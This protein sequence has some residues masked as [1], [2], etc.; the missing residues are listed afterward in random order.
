MTGNELRSY[1]ASIMN[2]WNGA[3][4]GSAKHKEILSIYNA[5]KPLARGYS[6]K[7]SDAYCATTVSAA[8]IK[9][10]IS[11]YTGTECGV[12][13]LVEIAQAK[14]IWVENDA[15]TPKVG[16]AVVYDWEDGKD[17]ATTDNRGDEDHVGI[18]TAV[19]GK[20]F[21]V[22]EGNI[23]QGK[24]GTRAMTVNGRYIRGFICPDYDKIAKDMGGDTVAKITGIDISEFQTVTDWNKVK[25]AGIK[26]VI[27]RSGY[28]KTYTD[29]EF[30][31][32]IE[33]AISVGIP[34]GIYHFSYALSADGAKQE[35]QYV[36]NLLKPYKSKI[37]LPVFYDFEGATVDYAKKQGV[38]LG[39]QQFNDFTVAF[40]DTMIAAG[41]KAGTYFNLT[42]YDNWVDK[43]RLGKYTRWFAQYNSYAQ[44][45]WFDLWQYS[46]SGSVNGISGRVDMNTADESLINGKTTTEG[47]QKDSKG[48]WY[49]YADG[50]WPASTWANINGELYWFN[51]D[52]YCVTDQWVKGTGSQSAWS[53]YV[54]SDGKIVKNHTLKLDGDGKL[55]PAG[56]FY[57]KLGDVTYKEFRSVLDIL[58][59]KGALKGESGTG[60]NMV[61]N[62]SE[63]A[64]RMFVIQHRLGM[65]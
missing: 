40:C 18:I 64:V 47:W 49:R 30:K 62:L 46:S 41:Y 26:F 14:G 11:D 24:T 28:G 3:T 39:K 36:I 13:Q 37:T 50:T 43:S 58:V 63:E 61:I 12:P 25:A 29:A 60:D 1:V 56:V 38:T 17:Y 27:I 16:D 2:G 22:V 9:A 23:S 7:E 44:C 20:S 8:W 35:A 19:S 10:G 51:A 55:V 57:H 31:K 15:Y 33:G 32:N 34:F 42:Y 48:W 6:V 52:G 5:H 59:Q 45:D 54:G 21:T 65:F 53:F 4:R